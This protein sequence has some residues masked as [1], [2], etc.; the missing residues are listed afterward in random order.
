VQ[1]DEGPANKGMNLTNAAWQDGAA[2]AG[3]AP[4]SVGKVERCR[5]RCARPKHRMSASKKE[6]TWRESKC[7]T[8]RIE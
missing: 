5:L 8:V 3:Y 2:F 7:A 4:C 1:C 6:A